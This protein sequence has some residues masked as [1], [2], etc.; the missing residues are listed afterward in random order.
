MAVRM[1]MRCQKSVAVT[2]DPINFLI[3]KFLLIY[4]GGT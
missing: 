3:A 4:L 2:T 1:G